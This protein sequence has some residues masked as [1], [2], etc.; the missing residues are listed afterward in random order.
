[1]H[2]QAERPL[3]PEDLAYAVERGKRLVAMSRD[4]GSRLLLAKQIFEDAFTKEVPKFGPVLNRHG[5]GMAGHARRDT[6]PELPP[7]PQQREDPADARTAMEN[8]DYCDAMLLRVGVIANNERKLRA[9]LWA[10]NVFLEHGDDC[11]DSIESAIR[12]WFS[13]SVPVLPRDTAGIEQLTRANA[14]ASWGLLQRVKRER[15]MQARVANDVT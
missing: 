10:H 2:S 8:R 5:Y 7:P 4:A 11:A 15:E 3:S 6:V 12:E 13:C 9:L 1:M 14:R